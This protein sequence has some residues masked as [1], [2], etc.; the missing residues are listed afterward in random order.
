[1]KIGDRSSWVE[2]L[3]VPP[4][5]LSDNTADQERLLGALHKRLDDADVR[6]DAD[7]LADTPELLVYGMLAALLAAGTWLLIASASTPRA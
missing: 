4:P 2:T 3:R 5:S 7:L 6:L 1:M